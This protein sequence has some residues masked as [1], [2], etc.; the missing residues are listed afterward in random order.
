LSLELRRIWKLRDDLLLDD[1][2]RAHSE[3]T[4]KKPE[5]QE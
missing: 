1:L 5:R 2:L 4:E 3:G